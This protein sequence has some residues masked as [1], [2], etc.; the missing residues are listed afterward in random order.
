MNYKKIIKS[1]KLRFAIL[2]SLSWIPDRL[3]LSI[4]YYIKLGRICDLKDPK[5]WTEK[6]QV[7]NVLS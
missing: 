5:R 7:Y 1:Q 4:Q 3:M 6:L 2:K